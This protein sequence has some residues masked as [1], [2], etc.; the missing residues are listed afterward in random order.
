RK[1]K[2]NSWWC[3]TVV[4]VFRWWNGRV[5]ESGVDERLYPNERK[6][7]EVVA[8]AVAVLHGGGGGWWCFER[9]RES[10]V[11]ERVDR[12]T[13]SLFGFAGKISPEKFSGGKKKYIE[14]VAVAVAVLHGGGGGWWCFERVRESGVDERVDRVTGRRKNLAGKVFRRWS[15]EAKGGR[16]GWLP[17]VWWG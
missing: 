17:P 10:G 3:C 7:I 2:K 1:K 8:V 4:V 16:L 13:G 12:V 14:V 9:V 5:R 11:D 6:K 15:P